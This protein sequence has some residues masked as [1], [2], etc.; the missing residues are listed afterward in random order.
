MSSNTPTKKAPP[1]VELGKEAA[2]AKSAAGLH[3]TLAAHQAA[4]AKLIAEMMGKD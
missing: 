3:P 4:T 1:A 2:A